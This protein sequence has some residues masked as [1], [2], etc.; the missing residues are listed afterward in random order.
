MAKSMFN[1]A[2]NLLWHHAVDPLARQ[3]VSLLE[4][5]ELPDIGNREF[6]SVQAAKAVLSC[7]KKSYKCK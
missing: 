7:S 3:E 1:R 4:K 5:S 2:I 6:H